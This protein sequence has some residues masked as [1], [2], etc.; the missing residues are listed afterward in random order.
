[1]TTPETVR[2]AS[3]PKAV[4][5]LSHSLEGQRHPWMLMMLQNLS[6]RVVAEHESFDDMSHDIAVLTKR[7]NAAA[8]E[9]DRM[10]AKLERCNH[11]D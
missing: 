4:A 10:T 2:D 5:A 9:I 1:M 6:S 11:A 8:R 7:L 3:L